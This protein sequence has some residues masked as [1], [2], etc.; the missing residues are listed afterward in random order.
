W[1]LEGACLKRVMIGG[2]AKC[3][4]EFTWPPDPA[5]DNA[6]R[7]QLCPHPSGRPPSTKRSPPRGK[8]TPHEDELLIDLKGGRRY[9]GR[10]SMNGSRANIL[11]GALRLCRFDTVQS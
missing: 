2:V 9:R 6:T 5:G 4:V 8:F 11:D 7:K 3:H 1:H 10:R